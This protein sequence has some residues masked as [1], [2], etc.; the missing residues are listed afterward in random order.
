MR[1]KIV[2]VIKNWDMRKTR[3]LAFSL[4]ANRLKKGEA[5]IAFNASGTM[6]RLVD[7]GHSCITLWSNGGE[8]FD[9]NAVTAKL[10]KGMFIEFTKTKKAKAA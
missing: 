2:R 4:P 8:V 6:A 3:G 10:K 7:S 5:L 9:I 1:V